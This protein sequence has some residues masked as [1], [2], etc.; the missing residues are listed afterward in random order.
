MEI[1]PQYA[2][3]LL[4]PV[5]EFEKKARLPSLPDGSAMMELTAFS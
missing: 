1:I 4:I 2:N 3:T 5:E